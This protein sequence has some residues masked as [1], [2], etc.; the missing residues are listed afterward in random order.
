MRPDDEVESVIPPS[1]AA[2]V[3]A[4]KTTSVWN[5]V[6]DFSNQAR[7]EPG[8]RYDDFLGSLSGFSLPETHARYFGHQFSQGDEGAIVSVVAPGREEGAIEI[9]ERHGADI[10]KDAVSFQ[11]PAPVKALEKNPEGA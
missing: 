11:Y 5:R 3:F 9:L 6:A 4:E 1:A 8:S 2:V 10:G 7:Q